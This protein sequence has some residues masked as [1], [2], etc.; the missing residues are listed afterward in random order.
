MKKIRL[1]LVDDHFV[2]RRGLASS[3]GIEDDLTIV[4]EASNGEDAI[5]AYEE[6]R[7]D[8]VLMDWQ[9]PRTT[10]AELTATLKA[11][12]PNARVL[13]LSAYDADE[14]VYQAAQADAQGYL[15]KTAERE[16][17]L[18][19]IRQVASGGR[20]FPP[21]LAEKLAKRLREEDVT[22][23]EREVLKRVANGYSNKEIADQLGI[24]EGTVKVHINHILAKLEA[25]DRAHA[26][27][28]AIQRGII[29]FD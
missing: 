7:P 24:S 25:R 29:R 5:V 20:Y 19:A 9:L 2:V 18:H 8:L 10:G 6:H 13:I 22:V 27:S 12:D 23:R 16:Q 1:L 28:L 11:K 26:A 17:L 15:L 3:L 14:H 4:G 21:Q